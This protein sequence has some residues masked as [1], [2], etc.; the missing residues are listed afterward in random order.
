MP[1]SDDSNDTRNSS[2]A[3]LVSRFVYDVNS[4]DSIQ[5]D[6]K[7]NLSAINTSFIGSTFVKIIQYS[8]GIRNVS[9]TE[10]IINQKLTPL[11]QEMTVLD[12]IKTL[13]TNI[14]FVDNKIR[15]LNQN[16]QK[17]TDLTTT[18]LDFS[19]KLYNSFSQAN[20][21]NDYAR[22]KRTENKY[23]KGFDERELEEK[24]QKLLVK[25]NIINLSKK[26]YRDNNDS[27]IPWWLSDFAGGA[28]GAEG[29]TAAV[30][31][32]L[33]GLAL[34][35]GAA[36]ITMSGGPL[37]YSEND[38]KK[39][40]ANS[41][42][43]PPNSRNKSDP[44][45][46]ST[47]NSHPQTVGNQVTSLNNSLSQLDWVQPY[48]NTKKPINRIDQ[49]NDALSQLD[50]AQSYFNTKK[51]HPQ[52]VGDRA[53]SINDSLSELDWANPYFN[54]KPTT[55]GDVKKMLDDALSEL[56]WANPYLEHTKSTSKKS[57]IHSPNV[58][59]IKEILRN[60]N[61][62][63]SL[64]QR[65]RIPRS[66]A[67]TSQDQH[68]EPFDRAVSSH[69]N[70]IQNL[71]RFVKDP[72]KLSDIVS[73]LERAE[74]ADD[75][76]INSIKELFRD[77]IDPEVVKRMTDLITTLRSK[78]QH[79]KTV[80]DT[81]S[82]L[83]KSLS[84]LD[85]ANSYFNTP[86]YAVGNRV[87]DLNDILS[88]LDWAQSY[89]NA[90]KPVNRNDQLNNALSQL[91]WAQPY[92]NMIGKK[93]NR[94]GDIA[95]LFG[96][97]RLP[98]GYQVASLESDIGTDF[99]EPP[100]VDQNQINTQFNLN[101][102]EAQDSGKFAAPSDFNG[103]YDDYSIIS[104]SFK[105]NSEKAE[106]NLNQNLSLN[107]N[108]DIVI[109]SLQS[110]TLDAPD[111][112]L[113]GNVTTATPVDTSN[114]SDDIQDNSTSPS[115]GSV[116]QLKRGKG[117]SPGG[118]TTGVG[119]V[120]SNPSSI[121]ED[122]I[123]AGES[124]AGTNY[125]SVVAAGGGWTEV[126]GADGKI[127]RVTGDR[128]WRNNNPG[129]LE[130]SP[131]TKSYGAIGSDGRF[132]IFPNLTVGENARQQLLFDS[133]GYEGLTLAQAISKYA[134]ESDG[135]NTAQYIQ[136]LANGLGVSPNTPMSS[137][138]PDQKAKFS[139]IQRG[140][141]GFHQGKSSVLGIAPPEAG[142]GTQTSNSQLPKSETSILNNAMQYYGYDE[143]NP[144][145]SQAL[146]AFF[147]KSAGFDIDPAKTAWCAAFVNSVLGTSGYKGDNSL[148]ANDFNNYGTSV[149]AQNV[150]PGDI[151]VFNHHVAFVESVN[152]DGTVTVLGG[153]QSE[154]GSG[155]RGVTVNIHKRK[156]SEVTSFRR[157]VPIDTM[158]A[159]AAL[160]T[161][162]PVGT[163][164][165]KKPIAPTK[166]INFSELSK[167]QD[168]GINLNNSET[169]NIGN[170]LTQKPIPATPPPTPKSS[171]SISY[172]KQ[173]EG[174]KNTHDNVNMSPSWLA[175]YSSSMLT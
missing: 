111:I 65:N 9:N 6:T 113:I 139:T 40:L 94:S 121:P 62:Y 82:D 84:N 16:V 43:G 15:L 172:P 41:S 122:K 75:D 69:K 13:D 136:T 152:N 73:L 30:G 127:Y 53:L 89:F 39:M 141:E 158:T 66:I 19:K 18:L 46:I 110:I 79:P 52:T 34:A 27:N 149:S 12:S 78:Q 105:L 108:Q 160:K 88:Q 80:G 147:H 101:S 71:S 7:K 26:N 109:K 131:L 25:N 115:G 144:Q 64:D 146:S 159:Q 45:I 63:N 142:I 36:A 116:H 74:E 5:S 162:D 50:W 47:S 98:Q 154:P 106:V 33:G 168:T 100:K 137:L 28:A 164:L 42:L 60:T 167:K 11:K 151:A 171:K 3:N 44:V 107:V 175:D 10:Y 17:N 133:K 72:R 103:V 67:G 14:N 97:S 153:N 32:G 104:T 29:T 95:S 90:P 163:V 118:S 68:D 83:N 169:T 20:T 114:I 173:A 112:R 92:F 48:F 21:N 119:G 24:I 87:N 57:G 132:A 4:T 138:T 140:I 55:V 77:K 76:R 165:K 61:S 102:T 156:L 8:L 56:Q 93:F 96:R 31:I 58:P 128:N 59:D 170:T 81:S 120:V 70:N 23:E 130:Y 157:P 38:F 2:L 129:N 86:D 49:L 1:Y 35:G 135:N 91:N 148:A 124:A 117:G 123:P 99:Y 37:V 150:Q 126:K 155:A 54:A 134:P 51:N 85:W 143:R 125:V 22:Y 174:H 145:Q 166:P 161:G